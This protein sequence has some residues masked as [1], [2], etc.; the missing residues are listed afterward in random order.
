MRER[1]LAQCFLNLIMHKNHLEK[2][3]KHRFP[4][5]TPE[6]LIQQVWSG[7]DKSTFQTISQVMLMFPVRT[8]DH[9]VPLKEAWEIHPILGGKAEWAGRD[10]GE[11]V[12]ML[13]ETWNFSVHCSI[14]SVDQKT[15]PFFLDEETRLKMKMGRKTEGLKREEKI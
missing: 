9:I 6:R 15:R 2:Q 10:E 5:S 1:D 14:I 3:L 11:K 12:G 7:V 13:V 8:V 4:D